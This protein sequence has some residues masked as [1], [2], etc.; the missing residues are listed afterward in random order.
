MNVNGDDE[1]TTDTLYFAY[2]S[3]LNSNDWQSFCQN[4]GFPTDV[5]E[6][7]SPAWLPD[8]RPIYHYYS[9]T[10]QGGALD[11]IHSLGQITPG[12]LFRV[13]GDAWA[14]LD[15][16][17]GA[18]NY[19][20]QRDV[21]VL[22]IGGETIPAVTYCVVPEKR[23]NE[24][25]QPTDD[26]MQIVNTGLLAWNLPTTVH[27][28]A[29][30]DESLTFSVQHVFAYGLLQAEYDLGQSLTGIA[31]RQPARIHG[32]IFD[33]GS[34]PGWQPSTGINDWVHG[35]LLTLHQPNASLQRIDQIEGCSDYSEDALYHRV[36]VTATTDS[37]E[38]VLAW[39]YRYAHAIEGQ[40]IE[41][42]CWRVS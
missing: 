37:G 42:G 11:V 12:M 9:G 33:L 22:N 28:Q 19:Y 21:T 2:G 20:E 13:H 14:A 27:T 41:E 31:Q 17:E 4:Y 3:N 34:Y 24:F 29:A 8:Y 32:Q 26:Y 38:K 23:Q 5:L 1:M 40:P 16:K 30:H 6:P 35:E 18:P 10:R 25:V 15:A 36:L 7:V 39:C